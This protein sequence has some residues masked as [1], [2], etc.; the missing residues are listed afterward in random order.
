MD[1]IAHR[2]VGTTQ[3]WV[4]Q[5]DLTQQPVT[6]LVNAAN[7][8]LSHGGGVAVALVRTGGRVIEDESDA[9]VRE[10]GP[11]QQ[12][13]A[14]VT[15]AGMLQATHIIH[16]VGPRYTTGADNAAQLSAAIAA[17]LDAATDVEARSVAI[18]AVSTG[19]FGYPV[20]LATA[21]IAGTVVEWCEVHS[22]ALDEVRLVGFDTTTADAFASG[23][24]S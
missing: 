13:V 24:T 8:Q 4:V 9:W 21:I 17:A 1:S 15:T 10:H 14:A 7:E 5:G 11:L 3:I 6:A 20:D 12:G 16:V 23:L 18:P 19:V 22:G 2:A